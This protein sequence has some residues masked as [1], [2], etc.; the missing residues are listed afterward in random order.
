MSNPTDLGPFEV[1][2]TVDFSITFD[3]EAIMTIEQLLLAKQIRNGLDA[4]ATQYRDIANKNLADYFKKKGFLL[5]SDD[6]ITTF[7]DQGRG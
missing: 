6:E 5:L 3:N 1:K 4:L 7:Y 2:T